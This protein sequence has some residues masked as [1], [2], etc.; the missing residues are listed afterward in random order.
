MVVGKK[1]NRN[2]FAPP[3]QRFGLFRRQKGVRT[4]FKKKCRKKNPNLWV[5]FPAI[6][7]E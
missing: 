2:G 5:F 3:S 1:K 4:H 7:A 6:G